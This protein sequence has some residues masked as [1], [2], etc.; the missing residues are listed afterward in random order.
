MVNAGTILYWW[1]QMHLFTF[2]H[3]L[4]QIFLKL[5]YDQFKARYIYIRTLTPNT[6]CC[7]CLGRCCLRLETR[8]IINNA[9]FACFRAFVG[10][11]HDHIGWTTSMP[12]GS[13]N[14][15]NF[16][17]NWKIEIEKLISLSRT[18]WFWFFFVCVCDSKWYLFLLRPH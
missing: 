11:F 9:F 13:N 8:V 16:R 10:Q 4:D 18:F 2:K 5:F 14:S 6:L 7:I 3:V 1:I 17:K 15:W 12:F